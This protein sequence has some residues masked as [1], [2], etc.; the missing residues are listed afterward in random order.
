MTLTPETAV[1]NERSLKYNFLQTSL[2]TWTDSSDTDIDYCPHD[3]NCAGLLNLLHAHKLVS[4]FLLTIISLVCISRK[5]NVQEMTKTFASVWFWY[6]WENHN[7]YSLN[8]S[9]SLWTPHIHTYMMIMYVWSSWSVPLSQHH[10]S[11]SSRDPFYNHLSAL[12]TQDLNAGVS[13]HICSMSQSLAGFDSTCLTII[14]AVIFYILSRGA[15]NKIY[16]FSCFLCESLS[17]ST[18][19]R[20]RYQQSLF[21]RGISVA[22]WSQIHFHL[23]C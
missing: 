14:K 8:S 11:N 21:H 5:Q 10:V 13:H 1:L 20:N 3:D 2:T 4:L 9:N 6:I 15:Q 18:F 23:R 19:H 17:L 22:V 12:F 7:F 16:L